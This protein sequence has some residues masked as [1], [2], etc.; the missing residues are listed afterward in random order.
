MPTAPSPNHSPENNL[1]LRSDAL[2]TNS[3]SHRPPPP[4]PQPRAASSAP[5]ALARTVWSSELRLATPPPCPLPTPCSTAS[6]PI[7]TGA[8]PVP[9]PRPLATFAPCPAA[10]ISP[11]ASLCTI[12]AWS[13]PITPVT[14][15]A[16]AIALPPLPGHRGSAGETVELSHQLEGM[17]RVYRGDRC[18]AS[19][20]FFSARCDGV[21]G[22][23]GRVLRAAAAERA[24]ENRVSLQFIRHFL[25]ATTCP[26]LVQSA[27]SDGSRPSNA[28][29]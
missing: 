7:T 6:A 3:A 2:S 29:H 11:G 18:G 13:H 16:S 9:P 1:A 28:T 10:S 19:G 5:G 12:H 22:G 27:A 24:L 26:F 14:L 25:V 8:S 4:L 21:Q 20:F 15:G 23:V 17:L